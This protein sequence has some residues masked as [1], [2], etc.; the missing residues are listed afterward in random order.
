M[1]RLMVFAVVAMFVLASAGLVFAGGAK[2][3]LRAGEKE[4]HKGFAAMIPADH[5]IGV[6]QFYKVYQEVMAGKRKAYLIDVRTHPEFYAFHIEGTDH[7]HAGHMYTI[8]KKIK[9]PNAEIY[10]WCRT[11]HRAKY[12]AGFL[13]KYGYK[14]V[15]LYKGG[16]VGWAKAGLPFVNQFTGT[17]KILEY[18]KK[19]SALEKSFRIRE[20]HPY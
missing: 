3:P 11:S 9:D 2:N 19:P 1:K 12:V 7:I 5:I 10:V 4:V 17:F 6:D 20:F 15:W 18:R 14:N 8:P 16:V 13:Y